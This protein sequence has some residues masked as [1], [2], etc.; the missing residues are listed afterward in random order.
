MNVVL[1][2][3]AIMATLALAGC[4][5]VAPGQQRDVEGS[6]ETRASNS[7]PL[8][9]AAMQRNISHKYEYVNA[10]NDDYQDEMVELRSRLEMHKITY[11]E[12]EEEKAQVAARKAQR[13]YEMEKDY[14]AKLNSGRSITC[15]TTGRRTFCE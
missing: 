4:L 7:S 15:Q 13:R 11:M 3:G 6:Y 10:I 1:R 8:S 5:N 12:Y 14:E 2:A 9:N